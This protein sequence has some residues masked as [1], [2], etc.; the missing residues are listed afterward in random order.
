MSSSSEYWLRR[1]LFVEVT[2]LLPEVV[3]LAACASCGAFGGRRVRLSVQRKDC[4][5]ET[6]DSMV[7]S[8]VLAPTERYRGTRFCPH[9]LHRAQHHLVRK[10]QPKHESTHQHSPIKVSP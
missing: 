3:F 10:R 9:G 2:G 7:C 5:A 4:L 1:D 6:L 8:E